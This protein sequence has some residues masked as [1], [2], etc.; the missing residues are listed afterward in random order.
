[1]ENPRFQRI[2]GLE[3]GR[4]EKALGEAHQELE[5][6]RPAKAIKNLGKA[7]QHAQLAIEFATKT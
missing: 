3:I 5:K 7:W 2:A 1:M 6:G 4:A